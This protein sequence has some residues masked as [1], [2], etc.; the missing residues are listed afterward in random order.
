MNDKSFFSY[1][2]MGPLKQSLWNQL[3]NKPS[4]SA[5]ADV[6]Q[7]PCTMDIMISILISERNPG[8]DRFLKIL[9]KPV[10]LNKGGMIEL[11]Y[12]LSS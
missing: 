2:L 11:L 10:T 9:F 6:S 8:H 3:H 1:H 5:M 12:W 4:R 7:P